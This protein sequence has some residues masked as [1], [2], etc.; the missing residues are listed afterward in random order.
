MRSE[1]PNASEVQRLLAQ[2]ETEYLAATRGMSG[3]AAVA[4]HEAITARMEQLGKLHENLRAIV[5]NDATRLMA[6]RL[7]IL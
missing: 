7:E 3:F 1:N 5:G 6:E 4:K 2:I